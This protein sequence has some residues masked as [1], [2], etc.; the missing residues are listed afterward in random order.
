M[1][2]LFN[3][4][5]IMLITST[6]AFAQ[7][8]DNDFFSE[9]D[10]FFK[11]QVKNGLVN[12]T[13]L[14]KNP[15][16]KSL[17]E[18]VEQANLSGTDA[19][20]K[21]A[22]YINAYNLQVINQALQQYPLQSVQSIAGFFDQKKIT[23]AGERSTLNNLEKGK[24]LK[25]Y[26]DSRLHFVLVCGALG[27][28]PITNFAYTPE[29]LDQQLEQQ[30]RL[31]LN[32]PNFLKVNGINIGL[33]QIFN[34]YADDFGGN[35]KN[36]LTFINKYRNQKLSTSSKVNFYPYNWAINEVGSASSS[37]G[38]GNNASRYIVSSTIP[39][40]SIETKIFNNLYT[41]S[42]G[43]SDNLTDRSTFY[44]TLV[45]FLYGVN[46]NFNIGFSTRYR[47]VRNDQLPSTPFDVFTSKEGGSFRQGL[48]AF[49]PQIRWA[50][51]KKWS[52][53]SVQS[54]FV[55]AIGKEL[56]GSE[57]QP[58]IDWNGPTWNTQLFNDFSIGSNFSLF[59]ELDFLL[60]DIGSLSKGA[61][62]RFSTP[63]TAIFSYNP[64][65]KTTIYALGGF[66]PFWQFT[67]DYFVQGGL[68]LKYQFTP[69]LELELLVTDF[70]NKF[71]A[72]SGGQAGTYNLGIR[73]NL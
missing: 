13:Q 7:K 52:N 5:L 30:T 42:T 26:N 9:A 51:I 62:N 49:G 8:I 61:N 24:L 32:D 68:G 25:P 10:R 70:S 23:V 54:S 53:F 1:K 66:S 65:R 16:L 37:N 35:K 12:Y 59:T 6:F 4:L 67:F 14:K 28:P 15:Q 36:I 57:T 56:T 50:P 48:T 34:W 22:F 58:Y 41:Q 33:S 40:G 71:L 72:Q 20:T 3:L 45:S 29:S 19:A 47:R 69:K 38:S 11:A 46:S 2:N 21:K 73:F 27:C 39:K 60:E 44:T 63:V 64:N 18:K 43:S 55:F 31:A 17:L